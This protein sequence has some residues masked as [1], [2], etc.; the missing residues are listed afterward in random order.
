MYSEG[1]FRVGTMYHVSILLGKIMFIP[2]SQDFIFLLEI[3][4]IL[5]QVNLLAHSTFIK[6]LKYIKYSCLKFCRYN[7]MHLFVLMSSDT[8]TDSSNDNL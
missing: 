3:K 8:G 1:A 6:D 7:Y 2:Y 5:F 4:D